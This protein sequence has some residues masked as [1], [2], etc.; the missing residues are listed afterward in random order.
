MQDPPS[1]AAIRDLIAA[2][3]GAE[4]SAFEA[5]LVA[6][7]QRLMD[8]AAELSPA[9]DAAEHERLS[10]L[11]GESGDLQH[12]NERLCV[13]IR[14]GSLTAASPGLA[15][16]LRATTLEKLAIDQPTYAAYQ[17]ALNKG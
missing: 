3:G 6:A 2:E 1:P 17:R 16:H 15:A 8:R 12:L 14:E 4:R 7:A 5:R 9:S 13:R 11:L 10:A